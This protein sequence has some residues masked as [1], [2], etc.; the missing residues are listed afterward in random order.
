MMKK[1]IL[2]ASCGRRCQLIQD[3]KK[4]LG[5]G[6]RIIATDASPTA[7]ALYFAD[8]A[9]VVPRIDDPEYVEHMLELCRKENVGAITTLIDPEIALLAENRARFEDE[10]VLVLAPGSKTAELA[11]DKVKFARYL[12]ENGMRTVLSFGD[13]ESFEESLSEGRIAFPVFAKPRTGSGSVGAHVVDD[14]ATLK[15][16]WA[17]APDLIVQ[18]YMNCEEAD[19]DVYVDYYSGKMVGCFSKKKRETRIGGASKTVSFYDE[20]LVHMLERLVSLFEFHGPFDVDLFI[21]DGEYV[22]SEINPRFGGAYLHAFGCGVDYFKLIRVNMEGNENTPSTCSY[23][24]GRYM[25]MYDAAVMVDE[26]DFAS[27]DL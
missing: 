6:V 26:R 19:A 8:A 12:E 4:S 13:I 25:L 7:P 10:G 18:E 17:A 3:C 1:A 15:A 22:V 9:Y 5:D 21:K 27:Y 24:E 2:F 20:K 14:L 16:Q 11:F 23:P